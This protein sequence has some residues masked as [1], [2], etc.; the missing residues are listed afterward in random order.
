MALELMNDGSAVQRRT[1]R[2]LRTPRS[3]HAVELF[4]WA[5]F[6]DHGDSMTAFYDPSVDA[7]VEAADGDAELL[8]DTW[9]HTARAQREGVTTKS[10]VELVHSALSAP[11]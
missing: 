9:K 3:T 8:R 6:L 10:V 5:C 2:A 11:H 7:L 4:R 1:Y